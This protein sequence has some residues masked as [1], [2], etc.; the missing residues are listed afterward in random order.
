M[1][2]STKIFLA[3]VGRKQL[4]AYEPEIGQTIYC[5]FT[6]TQLNLTVYEVYK[7]CKCN[8]PNISLIQL[9]NTKRQY[10][11]QRI[12]IISRGL[13]ISINRSM[14]LSAISK[15]LR[16]MHA[17]LAT[18]LGNSKERASM[19]A[20]SPQHTIQY[21]IQMQILMNMRQMTTLVLH[22][23]RYGSIEGTF[24]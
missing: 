14:T 22:L 9:A 11:S 4:Q 23:D 10:T 19:T 1:K 7:C 18:A 16:D 13:Q 2:I 20:F 12:E 6:G 5:K 8:I 3:T 24:T 17:N 21:Q 15:H